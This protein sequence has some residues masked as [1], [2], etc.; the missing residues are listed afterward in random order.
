MFLPDQGAFFV[1]YVIAAALVGSGMELLRLP[2]LL[3]YAIRLMLA[4]SAAERKY[5]QQHQAYE[6]EYGA[7]Y[8]WTLCLF[9]VIMAYSIICP[10]IV[11]FG[12]LYMLL[13][14]LVDRH[15]LFFAYLPTRLDRKVHLGAVDQALA[16]PIICLIWL[17]FFSVLRAG[18]TTATSLFTLVVLCF[19]ILICLGF[20]C[21]GHFKYLSPH[22]YA[23]KEED[24]DTVEGVEENT[25]VYLPRV[26][27]TQSP[28]TT[29]KEPKPQ[30]SYGSFEDSTPESL[31]PA[32]ST[33]KEI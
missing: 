29:T 16:A 31:S 7:M 24:E 33:I 30:Q 9:T 12:L 5:V 32:E 25:K 2:G 23:V 19:T 4:R 21:F 8:G 27:D 14:H 15:N 3:L 26:L 11:P 1:N 18:F 20:T 28:A 17:Y 10:I 22:N 13:K 6:F